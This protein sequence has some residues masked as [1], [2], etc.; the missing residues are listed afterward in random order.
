MLMKLNPIKVV[1]NDKTVR[2]IETTKEFK[3]EIATVVI[4]TLHDIP[5]HKY[6]DV[7]NSTFIVLDEKLHE[8]KI[9]YYDLEG[10]Y[11]DYETV[12]LFDKSVVETLSDE[13][14]L[15]E[16]IKIRIK[17]EMDMPRGSELEVSNHTELLKKRTVDKNARV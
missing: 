6:E 13:E 2:I 16:E 8:V 11:L 10:N 17:Q 14:K 7:D 1:D 15:Y 9:N 12:E 5:I 3:K 4:A